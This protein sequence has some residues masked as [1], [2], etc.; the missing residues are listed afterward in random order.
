MSKAVVKKH[1]EPLVHIAKRDDMAG[2]Q[3]WLIR[4]AAI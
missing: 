3:A 4:L 2:W 1:H